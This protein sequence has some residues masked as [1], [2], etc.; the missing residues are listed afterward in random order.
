MKKKPLGL[1]LAIAGGAMV[2]GAGSLIATSEYVGAEA[3]VAAGTNMDLVTDAS[4]LVAGDTF[5]IAGLEDQVVLG[6]YNSKYRVTVPADIDLNTTSLAYSTDYALITLEGEKGAWKLHLTLGEEDAY[7]DLTING[8]NLNTINNEAD[9]G[10]WTIETDSED[11][12]FM[13]LIP[14]SFPAREIRSNKGANRFACYAWGSTNQ[15]KVSIFRTASA[16]ESIAIEGTLS[17][18]TYAAGEDW[19]PEGLTVKG[20][21]GT[22]ITEAEFAWNPETAVVGTT[23]VSVTATYHGMTSPAREFD[24]TVND[25]TITGIEVV[26]PSFSLETGEA[27]DLTGLTVKVNYNI[28]DPVIID[29]L[30]ALAFS[31]DGT[32][33]ENG[34]V[35]DTVG[36]VTVTVTYEGHS[37][38]F[39]VTVT[40]GP[41]VEYVLAKDD[42]GVETPRHT[43]EG[44]VFEHSMTMKNEGDTPKYN[45]DGEAS[46]RGLQFGTSGD[47]AASVTLRAGILDNG[48]KNAITKVV[49]NASGA[50]S[51][52][53]KMSVSVNK[54]QIGETV[55]LDN[56]ATA[57]EFNLSEA[58]VGHLDITITQTSSKAIYIK[59]VNIYAAADT[60]G[61]AA[62]ANQIEAA[63]V[64]DVS[65][66]GL[67]AL[68]TV[69]TAYGELGAEAKAAI[70][71]IW[72]DDYADGDTAH[73]ATRV[74]NRLTVAEK[75]AVIAAVVSAP[76]PVF[77]G[78]GGQG[79]AMVTTMVVIGSLAA[80]SLAGVA[81]YFAIRK[82]KANRA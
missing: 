53:A 54:T 42:F 13:R 38:T 29:D 27:L 40:E 47:P 15:P 24:V 17:K 73:V 28:G 49:V 4:T 46:A 5:V 48:G 56:I 55:S 81:V 74:F 72:L 75:M 25:R 64:C 77:N 44:L 26:A 63:D 31:V 67:A 62:L 36:E 14:N 16:F 22:L 39:I 43:H 32:P 52:N 66:E 79:D 3:T 50:S 7:L 65:P 68:R 33:I 57:Y 71:G 70:D 45:F 61:I 6:G 11:P 34:H 23:K 35:F 60:L 18:T 21:D 20:N 82:K 76:T 80:V 8:N 58:A 69:S 37:D 1:L 10:T 59:S 41:T 30:A 12:K 78:L 2:L 51:T 19:S 9:A